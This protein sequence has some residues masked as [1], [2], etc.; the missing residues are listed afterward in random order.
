MAKKKPATPLDLAECISLPAAAV[1]ADVSERHLRTLVDDG[2][3]RGVKIGR[4]Y[5]VSEASAKAFR[6]HPS[7][8]RPRAGKPRK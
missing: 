6:R 2:K 4:N 3:V 1:L 7:M 5:L 8:G